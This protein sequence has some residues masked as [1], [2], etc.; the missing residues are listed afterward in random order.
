M[1]EFQQYRK[2]IIRQKQNSENNYYFIAAKIQGNKALIC[3]INLN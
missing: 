2:A 3:E 1:T